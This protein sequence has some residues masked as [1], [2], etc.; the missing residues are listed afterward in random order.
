MIAV[1]CY[2]KSDFLDYLEGR[3]SSEMIDDFE[4]HILEECNECAA[5]LYRSNEQL[6]E[7]LLLERTHEL[8]KK[9][10]GV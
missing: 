5:Q 2:E 1:A 9:L 7:K 4:W 6:E 3:M 8:I 10:V